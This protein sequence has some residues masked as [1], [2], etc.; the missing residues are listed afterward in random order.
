MPMSA[1]QQS[2]GLRALGPPS[3][4][5]E[6]AHSEL[7]DVVTHLE[8]AAEAV[9]RLREEDGSVLGRGDGEVRL[10]NASHAIQVALMSIYGDGAP[11]SGV[12]AALGW[13]AAARA[14]SDTVVLVHAANLDAQERIAWT[15]LDTVSNPLYAAGLLL[16]ATISIADDDVSR[17]VAKSI[18]F[19]DEAMGE[20][21]RVALE[22]AAKGMRPSSD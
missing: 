13:S 11:G 3:D 4:S 15:L 6:L 8:Q 20:L 2:R 1:L 7:T 10:I 5:L 21:R 18:D 9:D 14:A 19:L 12:P 17:R 16:Q 22:L